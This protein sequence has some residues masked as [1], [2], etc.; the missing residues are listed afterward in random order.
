M[1]LAD[2]RASFR[3]QDITGQ[4]KGVKSTNYGAVSGDVPAGEG[5]SSG[6]ANDSR[7]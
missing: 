5:E 4:A 3:W 6:N 1:V 7:G 2:F